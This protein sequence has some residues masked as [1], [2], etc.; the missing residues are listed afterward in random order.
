MS[1]VSEEER[2]CVLIVDDEEEVLDA[3]G[4]YLSRRDLKVITASSPFEVARLAF[5]NKPRIIVL[6]VMMPGLDGEQVS[7]FLRRTPEVQQ[8]P[9]I[10]YSA[11]DED[12]LRRIAANN[13]ATYVPKTGGFSTLYAEIARLLGRPPKGDSPAD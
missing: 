7:Q 1:T 4:R 3:I 10:F 5:L 9:V 12:E 6:D 13:E 2:P 11:A 8:T